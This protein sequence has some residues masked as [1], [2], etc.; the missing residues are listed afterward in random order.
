MFRNA[1]LLS[2][3]GGLLSSDVA[4]KAFENLVGR[5][6]DIA[7]EMAFE[8]LKIQKG[9]KG[10]EDEIIFCEIT[11]DPSLLDEPTRTAHDSFLTFLK[12][13]DKTNNTKRHEDYILFIAKGAETLEPKLT[14]PKGEGKEK[15]VIKETARVTARGINFIK[16]MIACS[17]DN[18]ERMKFC[19]NRRV[20]DEKIEARRKTINEIFGKTKD[21]TFARL[22]IK[23]WNELSIEKLH[24]KFKECDASLADKIE[25]AR[26]KLNPKAKRGEAVEIPGMLELA[27]S[28]L[29][30]KISNRGSKIKNAGCSRFNPCNWFSKKI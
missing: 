7:G 29:S 11:L 12:N 14:F 28:G 6:V 15:P 10:L 5:G 16:T 9:G 2:Y 24:K 4:K 18:T 27:T 17:S 1:S 21:Y 8:R 30:K 23:N 22:D 20:F 26:L 25:D 3:V 13:Y 19:L